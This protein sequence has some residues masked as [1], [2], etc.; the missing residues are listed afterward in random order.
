MTAEAKGDKSQLILL[1]GMVCNH[2]AW[3]AQ[4]QALAD[5]AAIA[6]P[7]YGTLRSFTEMAR[8]VLKRVD[9]CFSVAGHSMGGRIALELYRLAPERVER[10]CLLSSGYKPRPE[11]SAGDKEDAI[12]LELLDTARRR[13]MRAMAD[14]WLPQLVTRE[15][16][17]ENSRA[18]CL[19]SMIE[20]H[21]PQHLEAQILAG[22]AR[23]DHARLLLAIRCPTLLVA[24]AEDAFRPAQVLKEAA[25]KIPNARLH[26][27]PDC[28]HMPMMEKPELISSLLR[29]WLMGP[30]S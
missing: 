24:G 14:M 25:E 9:G 19:R 17:E 6:V 20:G 21:T 28:G 4:I 1:P 2:T 11:G 23:P 8:F 22:Q 16:L 30:A 13:G 5:V 3:A 10:L 7:N 15:Y 26:V 12:R 18:D 27:V 29:D